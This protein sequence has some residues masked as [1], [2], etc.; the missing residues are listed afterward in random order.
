[1][2]EQKRDDQLEHTYSSHVRIRDGALKTCQRQWTIGSG[3]SVLSARH[4]DDDDDIH[5]TKSIP[6]IEMHK[7]LCVFTMQKNDV[8]PIWRPDLIIVNKRKR[9]ADKG[10]FLLLRRTEWKTKK[11]IKETSTYTLLENNK[12]TVTRDFNGGAWNS[13]QRLDKKTGWVGNRKTCRNHL[14]YSIIMIV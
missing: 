3:I 11:P 4:D 6:E 1:M 13:P 10:T 5:K 2:A 14:N 12:L 7:I 8:I 9:P